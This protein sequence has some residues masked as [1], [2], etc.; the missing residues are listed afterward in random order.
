METYIIPQNDS[1]LYH[2]GVLRMRWGVRRYQS[3]AEKPRKSGE[4]G[5]ELGDAKKKSRAYGD[6]TRR[7][8]GKYTVVHN[9]KDLTTNAKIRKGGK[10]DDAVEN[11]IAAKKKGDRQIKTFEDKNKSRTERY[12]NAKEKY[13]DNPNLIQRMILDDRKASMERSEE[14]LESVKRRASKREEKFNAKA[15]KRVDKELSNAKA[16]EKL[17]KYEQK[18]EDKANENARKEQLREIERMQKER[19]AKTDISKL[20]DKELNELNNRIQAENRYKENI[21]ISDAK[22]SKGIEKTKNDVDEV[23]RNSAKK[24]ATITLTA[25]GIYAAK[26]LIE[27][28]YPEIAKDIRLPKK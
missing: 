20:S 8:E 10:A 2:H 28:K 24:V 19:A 4:G 13:G 7:V 26:K 17:K 3:Y 25:A 16:Q 15:E 23:V 12:N 22:K 18:Q 27:K 5:K 21:S 11:A 9:P 14:E 6:T 1:E